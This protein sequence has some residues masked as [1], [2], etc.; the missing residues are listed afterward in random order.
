MRAGERFT[1]GLVKE[2]KEEIAR[3]LSKRHVPAGIFE[4]ADIPVRLS[5][6]YC[7]TT[8]S[9]SSCF[10]QYTVNNKKIEI[11]VKQIVSGTSLAPSGTVA[12]PD[13][14]KLYQKYYDIE[15]VLAKEGNGGPAMIAKPK[16]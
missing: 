4:V 6:F 2:I 9:N 16:L 5:S 13:S 1:K 7:S 14:L 8:A 12:N 11:A 3:A 10:A 15:T